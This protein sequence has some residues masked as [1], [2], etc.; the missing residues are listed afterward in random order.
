[1]TNTL[2]GDPFAKAL[3]PTRTLLCLLGRP[4]M[5]VR[6]RLA[7]LAIRPKAVSLLTYLALTPDGVSRRDVARLLFAE[8]EAP[9]AA[10]RWHLAHLRAAAPPAIRRALRVD[11]DRLVLALATDVMAFRRCAEVVCRRP[12]T[13]GAAQALALYR[14]DLLTGVSLSATAEFDN[15]LYVEQE[16]LRR[17]FRRAALAY[18]RWALERN[19]ARD[20]VGPL[21]RL[22]TVDP[23]C[24]DAHVLLVQ[25]YDALGE[26]PQA[27]TTYRRYARLVRDELAAE[28]RPSLAAKFEGGTPGHRTLPREYLVPLKEVTLHVVDWSGGEPAILGVHGSAGMAHTLGALAEKLAPAHRFIGV[29]LRGHGFSDKPPAGYDLERHVDDVGQLIEA[30]GLRRPVLLGHSAGGTIA[31]FVAARIDDVAGVVLLEAM[32]GERAF[33]ENAAAQSAPLAEQLADRV[34]GFAAYLTQ[35]RKRRARYS[36]EAERLADRWARFAL[37]PLSDGTYRQRAVRAAVE[38]EWRSIIDADSLG[39]LAK[40]QCPILIVQAL[41][42]WFG[43]RPYFAPAIVAAQRRAAPGAELFVARDSDHSTLVRDPEPAMVDAILEFM[44]LRARP[45]RPAASPR[46][47]DVNRRAVSSGP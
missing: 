30:L 6:G 38:A 36:D 34:A 25:S 24:E 21:A 37:A 17:L 39:A 33:A 5:R 46:A 7:P 4:S 23:Y 42:P 15:W 2:P 43:G 32:I 9:L 18:A 3:A 11:G 41:G 31:A 12:A 40:V 13:R 35:W 44:R 26:A 16:D 20:A 19:A 10:L 8:A 45:S 27:A 1:M 47:R 14:A 28:P 29:D 22:V